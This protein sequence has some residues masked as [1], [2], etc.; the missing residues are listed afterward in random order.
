MPKI[1][2]RFNPG[3][4]F[5]GIFIV[6]PI[7]AYRGL[8]SGAKLIWGRM[9]RFGQ[10]KGEIF[11]SVKTVARDVGMG[12]KQARHYIHE[13][14]EKRFMESKGD[15]GH[16]N[17]YYFLWHA[18]FEGDTGT[19]VK[20][21]RPLPISGVP[22]SGGVDA[23]TPP[24]L[25]SP[26]LPISGVPTPPHLGST[27]LP[28]SGVIVKEVLSSSFNK[29]ITNEDCATAPFATGSDAS[30][31]AR[32][33]APETPQEAAPLDSPPTPP[34]P[35]AP[36]PNG[37]DFI[38]CAREL[39]DDLPIEEFVPWMYRQHGKRVEI[40]DTG[41]YIPGNLSSKRNQRKR[42]ELIDAQKLHGRVEFRTALYLYFETERESLAKDK[43]P[44]NYFLKDILQYLP[45]ARSRALHVVP[46]APA[47]AGR[48]KIASE[49]PAEAPA[50]IPDPVSIPASL[51]PL[52]VEFYLESWNAAV[53]QEP[54]LKISDRQRDAVKEA[55][56]DP[57]F[58][59]VWEKITH[60]CA[61]MA[62]NPEW[63]HSFTWLFL[64]DRVIDGPNWQGVL[65]GKWDFATRKPGSRGNN[66]V[67]Q[68][69]AK[70]KA[71]RLAKEALE[72]K[73][74]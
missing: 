59:D 39:R 38:A 56:A 74:A 1:G 61:R 15:P 54:C 48:G 21:S 17:D 22:I 12:E 14:V 33:S 57:E 2:D 52:T 40:D 70:A 28:I 67:D 36:P 62:E 29:R 68:A 58:R 23:E 24:H 53:P 5:G 41:K 13:L 47:T 31:T 8:S 60:K 30:L 65:D 6:N 69:I 27:P 51:D 16:S 32:G 73:L 49:P 66:S 43:W 26:P 45:D 50:S 25:G 42:E 72:R 18:A 3:E 37:A 55:I 34:V 44:L 71:E 19:P 63:A 46:D 7:L 9:H 4:M 64:R 35:L 20:K 10:R 11:P